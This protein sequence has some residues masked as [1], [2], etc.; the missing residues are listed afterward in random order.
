METDLT[1]A[2]LAAHLAAEAGRLLLAQREDTILTGAALGRAADRVAND[3]ILAGLAQW[4]P[5]DAILSEESPDDPARLAALRVWIVDPLD[6]TREYT[7]G[8]DDWAV[9][10]A[11]AIGE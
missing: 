5:G 2:E 10:V 3:L 6:G 8:R 1:D 7:E 11:L 4:R 9:H